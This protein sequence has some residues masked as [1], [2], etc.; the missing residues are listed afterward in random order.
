MRPY[1]ALSALF[2]LSRAGLDAAGLEFH[3]ALDWMWLSDPGD[4]RNRLVETLYYF[5]AFPPGMDALTGLLLK[6]GGSHASTL[7]HG[8]FGALGLV[9]VNAFF[10]CCRAVGLS[11]RAAFAVALAFVLTPATIYF[12][13][14]YLYDWPV[15][16]CLALVAVLFHKGML[17]PTPVVWS[18][19]F[20]LCTI[21]G[22][23]RSTFHL[24]WFAA[25]VALALTLVD[26]RARRTVA[27]AA[28]IPAALLLALYTKNLLVFGDFTAST[29]APTA[30]SVATVGRLPPA[31]RDAWMAEGAISSFAGVNVYAW[32]RDYA[33][34]VHG[35]ERPG[36]P[37]QLTRLEQVQ[38]HA[39]NFNHWW[40]LEANRARKHDALVYLQR[41]PL[42]YLAT[43]AEGLRQ[44]FGPSTVWHPYDDAPV[45]PHARHR[46]VLGWYESLY[47][48]LLHRFPLAPVGVYVLFPIA[49]VW[50]GFHV[51]TLRRSADGEQRARA[52]LLALCT[53]QMSYVIAASTM[54]TYRE[55][56]RYRYPIE[57]MM[58]LT[59][60]ALAASV[61]RRRAD[62][63]AVGPRSAG[64]AA[65]G[66]A[67]LLRAVF[68]QAS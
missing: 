8:L 1:V 68:T 37:P 14:L 63:P 66:P 2:V 67:G 34:F 45:S 50:S 42:D 15:T 46:L 23:T 49:F 58:W 19:L 57:W 33:P 27:A 20:G 21:I 12:E 24:V 5:H 48:R 10:Y 3:F 22:L 55:W 59:A 40:L 29:F 25:V 30:Y 6:A 52:A 47:N 41:R 28:I 4:L 26:R 9:L 62:V 11:T 44:M 61:A 31:V 17:R 43:V 18:V 56:S 16:A 36:W 13:H 35:R 64:E 32:P 38:V 53:M 51:W 39:A 60:A 65:L 7:A 54:L